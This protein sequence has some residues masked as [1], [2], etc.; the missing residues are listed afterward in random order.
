MR[1]IIFKIVCSKIC[2]DESNENLRKLNN[3]AFTAYTDI[4]NIILARGN[5]R[6]NLKNH[7]I[8]CS[9]LASNPLFSTK[10]PN[11]NQNECLAGF[12]GGYQKE[13]KTKKGNLLFAKGSYLI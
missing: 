5:K 3:I 7:F 12:G 8:S 6:I 9:N 4:S 10:R 2:T 11:N 1:K 13:I